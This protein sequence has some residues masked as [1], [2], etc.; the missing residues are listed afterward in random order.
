MRSTK[1][2]RTGDT[3][4]KKV[5]GKAV[6]DMRRYMVRLKLGAHAGCDYVPGTQSRA[7]TSVKVLK[8]EI[9]YI[10]TQVRYFSTFFFWVLDASVS[11]QHRL[12]PI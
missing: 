9:F 4:Q 12:S 5:K 2:R 1:G 6:I 8:S 7:A 11:A 10:K 3:I